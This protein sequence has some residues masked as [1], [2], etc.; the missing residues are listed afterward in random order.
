MMLSTV[1]AVSDFAGELS[2]LMVLMAWLMAG[3]G[4]LESGCVCCILTVAFGSAGAPFGISLGRVMRAV[5]FLGEAGRTGGAVMPDWPGAGGTGGRMPDGGGG[6]IAPEPA[7]RAGFK[8]IVGLPVSGGGL[9]GVTLLRGFVTG[10]EPSFGGAGGPLSGF[11]VTPLGATGAEIGG[12]AGA[13]GGEIEDIGILEVSFFGTWPTGC[14]AEVPGTLMRTVSR[15]TDGW[16]AFGGRVIRMVSFFVESSS[17]VFG[18]SAI[19]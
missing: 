1:E 5:S 16:S 17:C 19:K 11:V 18:E 14:G 10:A 8:G 2:T 3:A 6:G 7:G 13:G 9:G 12:A 15:F 4:D